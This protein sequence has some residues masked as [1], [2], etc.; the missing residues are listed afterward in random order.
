MRAGTPSVGDGLC[1]TVAI[2]N[3]GVVVSTPSI[4]TRA[5]HVAVSVL[6]FFLGLSAT[7][8]AAGRWLPEAQLPE[9]TGKREHFAAQ[10]PSYQMGFI[11]SSRVFRS[12][13]PSVFDTEMK[14][15]GQAVR[16]FNLGLDGAWPPESFYRVREVLRSGVKLRWLFVELLPINP[17]IADQNAQTLRTISWHDGYHTRLAWQEVW[18]SRTFDRSE[19]WRWTA[20]HGALFC[21]RLSQVSRGAAWLEPVLS[22]P[23]AKAQKKEKGDASKQLVADGF[24]P[25]PNTPMPPATLKAYQGELGAYRARR[26]EVPLPG[27]LRWEIAALVAEIRQTGAIPVFVITPNPGN[28]ENFSD[29]RGQGI[30]AELISFKNPE[31]YAAL[32]DPS[33][34]YDGPHLNEHGAREFSR[35]LAEEFAARLPAL[36]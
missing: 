31:K 8:L 19:K 3:P 2:R 6:A 26:S 11:G 36:K 9:W 25:G 29:L 15:R 20:L 12:F 13:V 17:R 4:F 10:A 21:K 35:L 7:W 16:S 27:H 23:Q 24:E 1:H 18:N 30:E 28:P 32:F 14:A 33:A 5:L 34:R 22:P